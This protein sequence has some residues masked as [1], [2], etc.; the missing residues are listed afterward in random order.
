MPLF[1]GSPDLSNERPSSRNAADRYLDEVDT[2]G[3]S[4]LGRYVARYIIP[5]ALW[6]GSGAFV[7]SKFAEQLPPDLQKDA[8]FLGGFAGAMV[9]AAVGLSFFF[10]ND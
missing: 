4:F 5:V 2:G 7:A 3:E 6:A 9:G 1:K 8:V 10:S